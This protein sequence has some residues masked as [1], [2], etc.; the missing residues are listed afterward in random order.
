MTFANGQLFPIPCFSNA[1]NQSHR[2]FSPLQAT[3]PYTSSAT[4]PTTNPPQ[5]PPL[6]SAIPDALFPVLE[7]A[8]P[9]AVPVALPPLPPLP[10]VAEAADWEAAEEAD[11]TAEPFGA[12]LPPSMPPAGEMFC[13]ALAELAA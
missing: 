10:P 9:V 7:A 2:I 1:S 3:A 4:K 6:P 11:A 8:A 12:L 13:V 5:T